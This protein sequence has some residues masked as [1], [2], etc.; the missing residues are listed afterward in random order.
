MRQGTSTE[1]WPDAGLLIEVT[2]SAYA[3]KPPG[4]L[5]GFCFAWTRSIERSAPSRVSG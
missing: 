5:G 3:T 4:T 1:A 2:S